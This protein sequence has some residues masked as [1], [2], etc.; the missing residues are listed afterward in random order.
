M[1]ISKYLLILKIHQNKISIWKWDFLCRRL[2]LRKHSKQCFYCHCLS[3]SLCHSTVTEKEG[4]LPFPTY[5]SS[6][7][8][9]GDMSFQKRWQSFCATSYKVPLKSLFCKKT[10]GY[11]YTH[12]QKC[13]RF[14]IFVS[15]FIRFQLFLNI[16]NRSIHYQKSNANNI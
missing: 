13:I 8:G 16:L 4:L 11:I 1:V 12:V 2:F 6:W 9:R 14:S 3:K 15:L 10:N 5:P 7:L